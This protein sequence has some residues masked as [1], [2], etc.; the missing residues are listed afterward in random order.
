MAI[1]H[2]IRSLA[3]D[4][5]FTLFV[6]LMMAAGIGLNAAMFSLA[7]A[8]LFRP[9]PQFDSERLA[10]VFR[11]TP[12]GRDLDSTMSFPVYR[13]YLEQSRSFASLAAF[14][15]DITFDAVLTGAEPERISGGVA[16][17]NFFD[18]LGVHAQRG[19]LF[20]PADDRAATAVAILSDRLWRTRFGA[21]DNIIGS[22]IRVNATMFTVVGV[23][24]PGFDGVTLD[25][26]VDIWLP[27]SMAAEA[28]PAF[29]SLNV[30]ETR[31]F[32]WVGVIGRLRDGVSVRAAQTELRA[33]AARRAATQIEPD[34]SA[35]VMSATDAVLHLEEG[36]EA[37][38]LARLMLG[39]VGLVLLIA[40]V[41]AGS[42]QLIRGERRQ[43][44]LAVRTA[45]GASRA[46]IIALI[47]G[48]SA[49]V[50]VIAAVL[51]IGLAQL[52]LRV[53]IATAPPDFPLVLHA[54]RPVLDSHVLLVILGLTALSAVLFGVAPALRASRVDVVGTMK[55]TQRVPHGGTLRGAL[56]MVQIALSV[57]LLVFAGLLL[58]TLW[59]MQRV[60]S[61]MQVDGVVMTDLNVARQG[62]SEERG[63]L[64]YDEL[65]A[66][67]AAN[68]NVTASAL[69]ASVPVQTRGM[70]RSIGIPG[71][72]LQSGVNNQVDLNV[73][74]PGY[75]RAVG[76][77]LVRGRDFSDADMAQSAP[78]VVIVN[79]AFALE[80]FKT[81]DVVGRQLSEPKNATIV[82]VAKTTKLR[83][84]RERPLPALT[85]PMSHIYRPGMT[86]VVRSRGS[87]R[88]AMADMRSIV[89]TLD[90][91]LPL[92]QV[93]TLREHVGSTVQKERVL[94][95][96]LIAFGALALLLA[97]AGLYS[98]ISY[99]TELRRK[100][101]GIRV[102][103]GAEEHDIRR[104]VLEHTFVLVACGVAIGAIAAAILTRL[105]VSLLYGVEPHDAPTFVVV[106]AL[107]FVTGLAATFA[108]VRQAMRVDPAEAL[109]AE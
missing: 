95:G 11:S 51:G 20:R 54:A 98:V 57:I 80:Y 83:S 59:A 97:A 94:A 21:R 75:F 73:T 37:R 84:M 25:V 96:L 86:L 16:T 33:I 14:T 67:V 50:A 6:V 100:E 34:A 78:L 71:V 26:P 18:T 24:P 46:R 44:E 103:I 64:F 10:R 40:C 3:R 12:D 85:M 108:P 55:G 31:D 81:L 36:I 8:I 1:R 22:E 105:A 52:A 23:A 102:A 15:W 70:R 63:R 45:L 9:F 93:R 68:P 28:M 106:I 109:R 66:R 79:E 48:E 76:V 42:L 62:Y 89:R 69:A 87:E 7:D 53:F 104:L 90:P 29:A 19:R 101:F 56:V 58:R 60:D 49:I 38:K 88:A 74:T 61:G 39:F 32:S 99:R 77:P 27:A 82:G 65:R 4:W 43:R 17:G 13:D 107:L 35:T 30:L 92:Y 5:R 91:N 72:E 2:S 41:N 47:T